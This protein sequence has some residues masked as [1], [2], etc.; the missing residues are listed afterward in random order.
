MIPPLTVMQAFSH[1][2]AGCAYEI[3]TDL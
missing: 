2:I 3:T 1:R